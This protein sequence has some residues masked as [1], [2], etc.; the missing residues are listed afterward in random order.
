VSLGRR[1]EAGALAPLTALARHRDWRLR[2]GGAEGLGRL[3]LREAVPVLLERLSDADP[4]VRATALQGL[5]ETTGQRLGETRERW[6]AGWKGPGA[7]APLPGRK[8]LEEEERR[9]G[10]TAA[11][12]AVL[13]ET[14]IW[15]VQGAYDRVEKILE[16]LRIPHQVARGQ[17]VKK[18]PLHPRGIVLVN[19]EGSLDDEGAERLAWFVRAG[20]GLVTTDWALQNGLWKIFPGVLERY[21]RASTGNDVVEIGPAPGGDALLQGIFRETSRLRWWLEI[22]AFPIE[23]VDPFRARVLIESLEM[24]RKYGR[25]A[26]AVVFDEGHG[27]ARPATNLLEHITGAVSR[28]HLEPRPRSSPVADSRRARVP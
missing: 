3:R 5:E 25:G 23:I 2:A 13:R 20:G 7:S 6:L 8:A 18:L 26:A 16:D 10:T 11:G 4:C 9:Y 24:E 1:G 27:R 28:A 17:E 22:S 15:V 12:Y 21:G 19:C 14:D